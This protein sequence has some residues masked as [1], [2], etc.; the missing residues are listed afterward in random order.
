MSVHGEDRR[1]SS[2]CETA[3]MLENQDVERITYL[4]LNPHAGL[5][6]ALV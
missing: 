3:A 5:P 6:P 2:V 4:P 1:H